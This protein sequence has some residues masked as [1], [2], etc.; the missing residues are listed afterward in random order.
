MLADVFKI[1]QNMCPKTYNFDLSSF[2]S[3]P[4]LAWQAALQKA[5]VKLYLLT[6]INM[7]LK[8]EKGIRGGIRYPIYWYVE[9]NNKHAKKYKNEESFYLKHQDINHFCGWAMSKKYL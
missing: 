9:A 4:G 8:V 2:L 6:D 7:L 1:S 5:K 3:A